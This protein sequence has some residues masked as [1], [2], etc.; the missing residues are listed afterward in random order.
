[1]DLKT[2][3]ENTK[4]SGIL[5]TADKD[6]MVGAAVYARPHFLDDG[7][8]ALIMRDRLTHHNLQS[9]SHVCY[10]YREGSRL[11]R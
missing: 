11:Q 2:Y 3:F 1:M 6:G 5:A 7:T 9:K 8:M 10:V 4:E